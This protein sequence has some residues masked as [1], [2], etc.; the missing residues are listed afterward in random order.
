M[1]FEPGSTHTAHLQV[2]N[3]AV[4]E[5]TY[6]LAFTMQYSLPSPVDVPLGQRTITLDPQGEGV[7]DM[8]ITFSQ[9]EQQS[10]L[11]IGAIEETTGIDLGIIYEEPVDLVVISP[12]EATVT[13]Y[14]D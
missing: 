12:P 13:L 14:W 1:Q 3:R 11:V 5:Y 6:T 8:P 7:V 4:K 9:T 10:V 2:K